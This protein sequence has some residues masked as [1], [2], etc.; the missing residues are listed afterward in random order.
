[1]AFRRFLDRLEP[2]DICFDDSRRSNIDTTLEHSALTTLQLA[3]IAEGRL[4]FDDRAV[5]GADSK[6]AVT[7]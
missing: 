1:L 3:R 5:L 2:S 6:R 4:A 7:D